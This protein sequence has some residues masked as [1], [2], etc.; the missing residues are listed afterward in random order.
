MTVGLIAASYAALS[1]FLALPLGRQIDRRG[2]KLFFLGGIGGM[3]A[4]AG[5]SALAPTVA[6]L[7]MG[8]A[9]LGIAQ[10]STAISFQTITA[11]RRHSN[12]D[13]GFARLA[14]A[15]S[16]GQ[17]VGP[18]I[19]G[20]LL[21]LPAETFGRFSQTIVVFGVAGLLAAIALTISVGVDAGERPR[22]PAADGSDD[23]SPVGSILRRQGVLPALTIGITVLTTI[24]LLIVYLPVL[25]E[26]RG[27]SP[28]VVGMLLSLRATAGL[29]SRL[30]MTVMLRRWGRA[31]TLTGAM[32]IAGIALFAMAVSGLPAV[33]A[34]TMA[35]IGFCLGLGSPMTMAWVSTQ[36]PRKDRGTV[37]AIRMT[38]N[39]FS[40]VLMPG[41]AGGLATLLGT[42][43]I[44][45]VLSVLLVSGSLWVRRSPLE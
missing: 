3:L 6:M 20:L 8:Q 29:V 26:T 16:S 11:N 31:P 45:V 7:A 21:D 27:I 28:G 22:L 23:G 37:L 36:T 35:V 18:L 24:D 39:R 25:G 42:G 34:V 4:G 32:L 17:L 13:R 44:F 10:L 40:Q 33:L 43:A 5:I 2:P 1:L 41:A 9:F 12:R 19:G 38:G 30:T 15:A 14:V